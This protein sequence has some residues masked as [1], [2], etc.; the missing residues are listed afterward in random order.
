[1]KAGNTTKV[2]LEISPVFTRWQVHCRRCGAIFYVDG[3][4]ESTGEEIFE[5]EDIHCGLHPNESSVIE[6]V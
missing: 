3:E 5:L 4:P 2:G 6:L 1:M